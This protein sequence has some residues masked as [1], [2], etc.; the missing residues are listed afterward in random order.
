MTG[1]RRPSAGG[2]LA[3]VATVVAVVACRAVASGASGAPTAQA[4]VATTERLTESGAV[5]VGDAAP[6]FGGWTLDGGVATLPR[7]MSGPGG[8][9]AKGLVLSFFATW[10]KPCRTG[11]AELHRAAP[12]LGERGFGIALVAVGQG[13]DEVRPYLAELGVELTAV[14]DRFG[15]V[16]ERYGVASTAGDA[17]LPRTFVL[18]GGGVVRAILGREGHDFAALLLAAS[19][20]PAGTSIRPPATARPSA[21][22]TADAPSLPDRR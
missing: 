8:T 1:R 7:L 18:D 10:C 21:P 16:A 17:T 5:R 13:A 12:A 11:L 6:D 3:A 19:A 2:A 15:K 4:V 14:E 20:G 22:A 9:S